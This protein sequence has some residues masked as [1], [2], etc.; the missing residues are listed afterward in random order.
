MMRFKLHR[1]FISYLRWSPSQRC[2]TWSKHDVQIRKD[3]PVKGYLFVGRTCTL[4]K[5]NKKIRNHQH[6]PWCCRINSPWI[7]LSLSCTL[8]KSAWNSS[9]RFSLANRKS[10]AVAK[11]PGLSLPARISASATAAAF[12]DCC[13]CCCGEGAGDAATTSRSIMG[14]VEEEDENEDKEESI[15][16]DLSFLMVNGLLMGKL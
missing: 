6:T 4:L 16:F 3:A 15:S 13:C 14:E 10:H 7:N 2:W 8:L 1:L 11:L 12:K 5:K 9:F